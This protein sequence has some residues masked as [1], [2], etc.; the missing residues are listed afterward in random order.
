S[1]ALLPLPR[2]G[3]TCWRASRH[4]CISDEEQA[5]STRAVRVRACYGAL[6]RGCKASLYGV[7]NTKELHV[8]YGV[9]QRVVLRFFAYACLV[10]MLASPV[11]AQV[12]GRGAGP[13]T[14][15]PEASARS[16]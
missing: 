4:C 14:Q 6:K 8:M 9:R 10:C 3:R 2:C 12:R 1:R 15:A 13:G 16:E 11:Y 7:V 5:P